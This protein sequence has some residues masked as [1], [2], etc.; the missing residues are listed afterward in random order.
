MNVRIKPEK[1]IGPVRAELG[2]L[3]E[4]GDRFG[5]LVLRLGVLLVRFPRLAVDAVQVAVAVAERAL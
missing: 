1:R 2:G 5:E 3:A 4:C